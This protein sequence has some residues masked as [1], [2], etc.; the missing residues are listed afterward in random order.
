MTKR[1]DLSYSF[2]LPESAFDQGEI[3]AKIKSSVDT[4]TANITEACGS[5]PDIKTSIVTPTTK[6]P[7]AKLKEVSPKAA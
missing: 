1:L 2:P 7:K 6:K 4:L 5:A 3:L